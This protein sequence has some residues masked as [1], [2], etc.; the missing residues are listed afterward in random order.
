MEYIHIYIWKHMENIFGKYLENG[1]SWKIYGEKKHVLN[2]DNGIKVSSSERRCIKE[3][4][5][6]VMVLKLS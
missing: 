6:D 3:H 4:G 1:L 2:H 5:H